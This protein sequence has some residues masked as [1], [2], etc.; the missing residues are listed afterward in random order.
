MKLIDKIQRD[1]DEIAEFGYCNF[2]ETFKTLIEAKQRILMLELAQKEYQKRA[3]IE[4]MEADEASGIYGIPYN[5]LS[6]GFRQSIDSIEDALSNQTKTE[7][8]RLE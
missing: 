6:E 4:M 8:E 3:L 7:S 1:I 2:A 5:A